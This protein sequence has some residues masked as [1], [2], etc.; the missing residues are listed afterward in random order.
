MR[1]VIGLDGGGTKTKL[2]AADETGKIL[3]EAE[4][5][6]SNVCS[7]ERK[8]VEKNMNLLLT[9]VTVSYT[10]LI[11]ERKLCKAALDSETRFEAAL[12]LFEPNKCR[13][14]NRK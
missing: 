10:H 1:Y 14:N 3:Y 12:S 2:V 9:P 13:T 4:G 7:N 8:T 6:P 11:K 5:G